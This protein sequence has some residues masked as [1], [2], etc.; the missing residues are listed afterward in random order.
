MKVAYLDFNEDDLIE[1]YSYYNCKR[2]GGGRVFASIA[3][4]K[5][6]D[7]HIFSNEKSFDNLLDIENKKN[8]HGLS[9]SDRL[10][11]RQGDLIKNI[12]PNA[13]Y[14]D[15]FVHHQ[16]R[17]HANVEGLKAKECCWAVS[18]GEYCHPRNERLLLYN[19][20]QNPMYGGIKQPKLY[21]IVI[22]KKIPNFQENE[23][24]D[25]LFQCT[26][27]NSNFGSI[28]VA[29]LCKEY[30]IPV[31]FAGPID[32]DYPLL[33]YVDNENIQYLGIID[34]NTKFNLLKKAKACPFIHN[35]P[36]PFNLSAIES[37]A[38]GTPIIATNVGFWSNLINGKNGSIVNT[39]EDFI[40]AL[41]I[42]YN[43]KDC[44]DSVQPYSEEKML[45]SFF[46][47]FKNIYEEN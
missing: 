41:K 1:D 4:E 16:S 39:E 17:Y 42:S 26:R 11:I 32:R 45:E 34:D 31:I 25:F 5:N 12:I 47:V 6:E 35:W 30:G 14:F 18:V 43:Q 37:L 38:Y 24:S 15:L 36:T 46:S 21:K 19:D 23:K 2:Y 13:D 22:G 8:C 29:K 27:H 33:D 3:K 28:Q 44:W 10:R 7:F 9:S 40:S 20:F